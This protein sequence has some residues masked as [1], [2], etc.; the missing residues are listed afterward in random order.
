MHNIIYISTSDKLLN[1]FELAELLTVSR[2]NNKAVDV[3]GMLLYAEGTFIQVL[4]GHKDDVQYIYKKVLNDYRHRNITE[5]ANSSINKRNFENWA[6]GF[7]SVNR[8]VFSLFEAYIDPSDKSRFLSEE[9]TNA[10]IIILK[11]FAESNNMN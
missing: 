9:D 6:M 4:E 1:D 8:E 10:A 5:L 7:S 11:S 2:E 3:T